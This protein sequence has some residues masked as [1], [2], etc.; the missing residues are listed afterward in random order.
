VSTV[1]SCFCD[2]LSLIHL[3]ISWCPEEK[4][5]KQKKGVWARIHGCQQRGAIGE[6]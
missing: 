5:I 6:G 1:S 3:H 2:A 4:I